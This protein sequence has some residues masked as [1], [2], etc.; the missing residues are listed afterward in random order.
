M[1]KSKLK[2]RFELRRHR[3]T[4][5]P[6]VRIWVDADRDDDLDASES[7]RMREASGDS[8]FVWEGVASVEGDLK[9]VRMLVKHLAST[10]AEWSLA[11]TDAAGKNV[12]SSSGTSRGGVS[13]Q[14]FRL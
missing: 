5:A 13:A 11:V 12:L 14:E 8:S 10:A 1:A 6:G 9:G 7:V 4:Y 2:F 3:G